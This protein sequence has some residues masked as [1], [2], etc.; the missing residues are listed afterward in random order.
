[1]NRIVLHILSLGFSV[2]LGG[3]LLFPNA[4]RTRPV[5][6]LIKFFFG[7]LLA[8]HYDKVIAAYGG[9]YGLALSRGLE[10]ARQC[11]Q[12]SIITIVDCGTGTGFVT[13]TAAKQFPH[14]RIVSVDAVPAML[15]QART[16]FR[17]AR[18]AATAVCGDISDLPLTSGCADLVIAQ[19]TI[20]FLAEFA[21]ICA[22]GGVVLFVDSSARLVSG[23]AARAA[24]KTGAFS[25]IHTGTAETGF[26]L[27]AER[28]AII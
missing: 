2:M 11:A 4:A 1:M 25:K 24:A 15:L 27:C 6:L 3:L 23:V 7:R 20:P 17:Q 12:R 5:R 9:A 18:I 28:N 21:R 22:P 13:Q 8:P 16:G 10:A 19:N 14:A 26:Y